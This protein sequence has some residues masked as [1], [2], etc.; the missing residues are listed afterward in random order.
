VVAGS[1]PVSPTKILG[2][3]GRFPRNPGPLRLRQGATVAK[4]RTQT[5]SNVR[6]QVESATQTVDGRRAVSSL[7]WP[8]RSPVMEMDGCPSRVGSGLDVDTSLQPGTAALWRIVWAPTLPR[9]A[10]AA[11]VST[12]R[13]RF[14]G[15]TIVPNSVQSA[16]PVSVH[17]PRATRRSCICCLRHALR[18][19]TIPACSH[20]HGSDVA[21]IARV[22][23]RVHNTVDVALKVLHMLRLIA[24]VPDSS[25]WRYRLASGAD[26]DSL[27][28]GKVFQKMYGEGASGFSGDKE[29]PTSSE[30]VQCISAETGSE[31]LNDPGLLSAPAG[32]FSSCVG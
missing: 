25:P 31:S 28:S 24:L 19:V 16:I 13:N 14:R 29:A 12:V 10:L 18:A 22:L 27:N 23:D 11:A 4:R 8:Y 17:W 1:N 9:L 6:S 32:L 7:V 26:V 5:S 20:P 15:P 2:G 3:E 21:S 30:C